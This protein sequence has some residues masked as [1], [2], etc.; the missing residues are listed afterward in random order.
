MAE[1]VGI[2]LRGAWR[3]TVEHRVQFPD[4]DSGVVDSVLEWVYTDRLGLDTECDALAVAAI[5]A[6]YGV[7]AL[8]GDAQLLVCENLDTDNALPLF[9]AS[10]EA[11]GLDWLRGHTLTFLRSHRFELLESAPF[12][13]LPAELRAQVVK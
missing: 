3:E 2:M 7:A 8:C 12:K 6:M 10:S 9:E 11:T 4:V 1:F 5:A 13:R